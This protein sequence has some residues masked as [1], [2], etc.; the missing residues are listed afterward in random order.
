MPTIAEMLAQQTEYGF[1]GGQRKREADVRTQQAHEA[2]M[3]EQKVTT[4]RKKEELTDY[5]A[6][7]QLR[8]KISKAKEK[9][10]DFELQD[11]TQ[12]LLNEQ[13]IA[14]LRNSTTQAMSQYHSTQLEDLGRELGTVSNQKSYDAFMKRADPEFMQ[15]LGYEFTGDFKKDKTALREINRMAVLSI[16]HNRRLEELAVKGQYDAAGQGGSKWTPET[17]QN[18]NVG[19]EPL[20]RSMIVSDPFFDKAWGKSGW[21]MLNDPDS[22]R[23]VNAMANMAMQRAIE[24]QQQANNM[25]R[26]TKNPQYAVGAAQAQQ[27]AIT[28]LK[29]LMHV[30]DDEGNITSM[31]PA[32]LMQKRDIWRTEFNDQMNALNSADWKGLSDNEKLKLMDNAILRRRAAEFK[33]AQ[34]LQEYKKRVR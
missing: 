34:R 5:V 1:I 21:S 32:E 10:A 6:D 14:E 13:Q 23:E 24:I 3:E 19:E 25:V 7:R 33:G 22:S 16:Q 15:S 30:S 12:S 4:Q 11:E 8:R 28:E 29:Y 2:A 9:R 26:A 18:V 27:Q 31:S 20:Y 17:S